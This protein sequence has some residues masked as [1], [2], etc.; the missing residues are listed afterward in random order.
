VAGGVGDGVQHDL[1]QVAVVPRPVAV[2][3]PGRAGVERQAGDGRVGQRRL[4]PVE[5]EDLGRRPLGRGGPGPPGRPVGRYLFD[6]TA[7]TESSVFKG[8]NRGEILC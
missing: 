3:P 7:V 5:V 1:V 4:V 6:E 2:G 8:A